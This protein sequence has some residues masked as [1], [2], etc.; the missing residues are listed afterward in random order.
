ML[1]PVLNPKARV[2]LSLFCISSFSGCM[3]LS[4]WA[5]CRILKAAKKASG[6][7]NNHSLT[8][9]ISKTCR[10]VVAFLEQCAFTDNVRIAYIFRD[11]RILLSFSI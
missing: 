8:G 6:T 9:R 4:F 2:F 11:A 1:F 7:R 10:K 5:R 3:Y